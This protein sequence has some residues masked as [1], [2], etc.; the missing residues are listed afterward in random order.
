MHLDQTL[1]TN[2]VSYADQAGHRH[3]S[4]LRRDGPAFVTQALEYAPVIAAYCDLYT[5]GGG[6]FLF[7][8]NLANHVRHGR[9][10][11]LTSCG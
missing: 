10:I 6:A 2:R 9:S 3:V 4:E 7:D 5:P 1:E 8:E 11:A